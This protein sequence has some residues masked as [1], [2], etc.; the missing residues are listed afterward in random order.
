[1][2]IAVIGGGAAGLV[3]AWLLDG[4][5]EVVLLERASSLGGNI[6]TLNRN[7]PTSATE[8]FLDAGVI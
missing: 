5:H 7:V 1:M 3:T 6:R 4:V 8:L 2:K